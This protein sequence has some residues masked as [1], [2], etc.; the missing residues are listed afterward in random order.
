MIWHWLV[1]LA[2]KTQCY[3]TIYFSAVTQFE[4]SEDK[5]YD[6]G[7][8]KLEIVRSRYVQLCDKTRKSANDVKIT[9][10]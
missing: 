1:L 5:S 8:C 7:L 9:Y 3:L 2:I 4:F 6:Q 10:F